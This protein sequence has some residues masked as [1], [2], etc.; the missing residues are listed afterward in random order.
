MPA[1][2][3]DPRKESDEIALKVGVF[4]SVLLCYGLLLAIGCI[5]LMKFTGYEAKGIQPLVAHSPFLGWMYHLWSV[6][7]FSAGLGVVEIGIALLIALRA[8]SPKACAIG[9]ALFRVT[10][11]NGAQILGNSGK[12]TEMTKFHGSK[13]IAKSD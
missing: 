11:P 9:S 2:S 7:Q 3:V 13:L 4:G 8:W 5:G 10:F 12:V 6:R 1:S